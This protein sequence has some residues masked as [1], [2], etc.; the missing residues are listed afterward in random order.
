MTTARERARG[1][2]VWGGADQVVSSA[3]NFGLSVLAGRL[4]GSSGLGV[5]FLGFSMYLLALSFVRGLIM[6][7]FVVAT[8]ALDR[9]DQRAATR[10]CMS[11]VGVAAAVTTAL[12]VLLGLVIGD[13]LGRSLLIFAPWT[14]V[15]MIQ[16][17]WRSVL[18]RDQ[19]GSGAAFNDGMWALGML[20]MIPVAFAYRYDWVIAATWGAGAAAG[21]VA[22]WWQ[23]KLRPSGISPAIAWWKRDLRYLGSWLAI[24]N[25]VFSAGAQL[26]IV[27]LAAQ[28]GAGDLGGIRSVDVVFAPMTLIGEAF[29][30]PGVPIVARALAI[31][32]GSARR[33]AWRLSGGAALL[34][35]AYLGVATPL[36]RQILS[37][38][39]GPE[40]AV[41]TSIVLPVALAQLMRASATGFGIL[42]KAD[43]R[44]HAITVCRGLTTGLGLVFGPTL[45]AL[46]GLVP[47]VWGTEM[48]LVVGSGATI[49]CGLMSHDVRFGRRSR[50]AGT[51]VVTADSN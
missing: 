5:V 14:G 15:A 38:L 2:L 44:V 9:D 45:A 39:F 1:E 8:A 49:V 43:R 7:P 4:L 19:R 31:S 17:L 35:G 42:I 6:E 41:F 25:V 22:G 48:S 12:M 10:A 28:L 29:G 27:L 51:P 50:R 46:Y 40:F 47:A 24:Q 21:A 36:S 23:I 32:A 13:P 3:T 37:R 11:L 16:D 18:F 33:W 26:T 20:A 34:V 30:F